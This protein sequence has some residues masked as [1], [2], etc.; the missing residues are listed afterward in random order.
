MEVDISDINTG[1]VGTEILG[2]EGDSHQGTRFLGVV[3]EGPQVS[4]QPMLLF[5]RREEEGQWESVA[6]ELVPETAKRHITA[7][8]RKAIRGDLEECPP[9]EI[10]GILLLSEI[11]IQ[12]HLIE[13]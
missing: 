8:L 4:D 10:G 7:E 11:E 12:G 6:A 3:L 9:D 1:A 5:F 2:C 13:P